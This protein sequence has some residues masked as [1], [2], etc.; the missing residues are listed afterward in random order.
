MAIRNGGCTSLN[1]TKNASPRS[2]PRSLSRFAEALEVLSAA[3]G[4]EGRETLERVPASPFGVM[5]A[6]ACLLGED[7]WFEP[8]RT[9]R[10]YLESTGERPH[11]WGFSFGESARWP[12]GTWRSLSLNARLAR[13]RM[14][15][16]AHAS[17]WVFA[18]AAIGYSGRDLRAALAE[19]RA[20]GIGYPASVSTYRIA[21]IASP[22]E[23][24]VDLHLLQVLAHWLQRLAHADR[25]ARDRQPSGYEVHGY[26]EACRLCRAFWGLR[27]R[28]V[29][30]IAPFHPGCR[31][32][33]QPR[34]ADSAALD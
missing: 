25:V 26:E 16:L 1:A 24:Y 3:I 32:F 27:P 28:S 33:S 11:L 22:H 12:S 6:A 17:D 8:L 7:L 21:A 9:F 14:G 10:T 13:A 5:D 29:D 15:S 31:C 20:A 34:F 4:R 30:W 18:P 2:L 23:L 19:L